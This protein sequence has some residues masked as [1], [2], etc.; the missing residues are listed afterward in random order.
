MAI[1]CGISAGA[2]AGLVP[3][4]LDEEPRL[5]GAF[6]VAA[7]ALAV[8]G[9]TLATRAQS[10]VAARAASL[11]LAGLIVAYIASR[12]TGVP[13]LS[14][15]SEAVDPIGIATTVV[16]AVGLAFSLN[17]TQTMGGKLPP[18][19]QEATP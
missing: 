2:H 4:H 13:A 1:A 14:P 17:L 7:I 6:V 15:E 9:A 10:V 16:E 8:V 3:A 18:T 19:H 12:T 11:V 5:G